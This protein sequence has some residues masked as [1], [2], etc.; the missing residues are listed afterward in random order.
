[1]SNPILNQQQTGNPTLNDVTN[2]YNS[3]KNPQQF[4]RHQAQI[5]PI[6]QKLLAS[7]ANP[8]VLLQQKAE[9]CGIDYQKLI[10]LL[11]RSK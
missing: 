5:N 2:A 7:N 4:L 8:W 1:M 9:E 6:F 10:G 3:I 11:P